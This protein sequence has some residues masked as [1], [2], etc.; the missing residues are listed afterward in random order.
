MAHTTPDAS[1][2]VPDLADVPNAPTNFSN[3]A[4][5]LDN[6]VVPNFASVAARDAAISSPADGQ[7]CTVASS[8]G[9]PR[10]FKYSTN[11]SRWIMQQ[12]SRQLHSTI[13]LNTQTSQQVINDTRI[14]LEENC[15]YRF[16]L[17][18]MTTASSAIA[19]TISLM[20]PTAV[21]SPTYTY[22]GARD[23]S[24]TTS[25]V[26]FASTAGGLSSTSSPLL[27]T[28]IDS[29]GGSVGMLTVNGALFLPSGTGG[30][31]SLGWAQASSSATNITAWAVGCYWSVEEIY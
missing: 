25:F 26:G 4:T 9:P 30:V 24:G 21:G 20:C 11:L 1:L 17:H 18:F 28:T 31:W 8:Q 6:I 19:T 22:T 14:Q 15:N 5:A 27:L 3:L 7:M 2:P 10:T 13:T 16:Y 29:Q 23:R 12:V